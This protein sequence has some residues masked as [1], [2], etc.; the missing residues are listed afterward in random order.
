M[1]PRRL[2]PRLGKNLLERG[3]LGAFRSR[4]AEPCRYVLSEAAALGE[5]HG[6]GEGEGEG[7]PANS[8][9]HHASK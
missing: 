1:G 8:L 3:R 9:K 7:L 2:C 4:T 6:E 5:K